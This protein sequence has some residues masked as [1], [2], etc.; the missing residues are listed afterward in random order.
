VDEIEFGRIDSLMATAVL[1]LPEQKVILSGV[2]WDT[3]SRLLAE[4]DDS[5]GTRFNYDDGALEIMVLSPEH[6]R[7]KQTLATLVELVAAELEIDVDGVGSTTFRREEFAKGFEAD[8]SFYVQNAG[9][10]AGKKRIDL[11]VDPPPDLA[12]E[13]D[14]TSP[15]LNKFAIYASLSVP[16]VWRCD[17]NQVAIFCYSKGKYI[18]V[19]MSETLPPLTASLLSALVEESATMKR[20]AWVRYVRE[21]AR[22]I[23]GR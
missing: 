23:A 21:S 3:Y 17:G 2:S 9:Q 14:I 16:E 20:S 22:Q 1:E 10:V 13:I 11:R 12:I 7:L 8:A 18:E 19:E 6:E 15:S 4:H 5:P